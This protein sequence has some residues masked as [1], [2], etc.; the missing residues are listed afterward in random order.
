MKKI[1]LL[2][3]GALLSLTL[4]SQPITEYRSVGDG[5]WTFNT[6]WHVNGNPGCS[7]N[8]DVYIE[9][10]DS[11]WSNC[12]P[13]DI[14]GTG[15]ITVRNGGILVVLG[16]AGLTGNGDLIV[17]PGGR[18]IV[19]GDLNIGGNGSFTMNGD[20]E[21]HGDMNVGGN[22]TAAG[23]GI[24]LIGGDGCQHW[25]GTGT[26]N[27]QALPVEFT[28]VQATRSNNTVIVRWS[29]ASESNNDYFTVERSVNGADWEEIAIINGA[30]NSTALLHY[31]ATDKT[32]VKGISYYRVK[33][34][35]MDGQYAYSQVVSMD[36]PHSNIPEFSIYPNPASTA[37][38]FE[39][40][41]SDFDPNEEV[42]I[43]VIDA[44]GRHF[45]SKVVTTNTGGDGMLAIDPANRLQPGVYYVTGSSKN[46]LI[47]KRLA[48][49]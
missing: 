32:P 10:G 7:V 16:N 20:A 38:A 40:Q 26:C 29:T 37:S 39:I 6:T 43:T 8:R 45:Y 23:S 14:Q 2:L 46:N 44:M 49:Q 28:N 30:G 42:L 3:S 12:N 24:I 47:K 21:V 25:T 13:Q 36:Y 33:Q 11:V 48:V 15:S 35:D 27:D 31:S 34:T 17:E 5:S 1:I 9:D 4:F 41:I 22:G 18:L 19:T